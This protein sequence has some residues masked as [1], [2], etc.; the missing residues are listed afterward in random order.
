VQVGLLCLDVAALYGW[1]PNVINHLSL[2][3]LLFWAARG[4]EG[5][6][7]APNRSGLL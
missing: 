7:K 2:G 6:K 1:P 5:W 3:E 4:G